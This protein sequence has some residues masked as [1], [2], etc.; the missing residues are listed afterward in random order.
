MIVQQFAY[1]TLYF[2][3]L[4]S[5]SIIK[6]IPIAKVLILWILE[7]QEVQKHPPRSSAREEAQVP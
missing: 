2:K 5:K 4:K 3:K 1:Q 7:G 6:T